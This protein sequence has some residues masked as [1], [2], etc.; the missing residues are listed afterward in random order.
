MKLGE[1]LV[2]RGL[3]TTEQLSHALQTQGVFGGRL[4]TNLVEMGYVTDEDIATALAQQY[5]TP[6]APP[7]WVASIPREVIALVPRAVAEKYRVIPLRQH[8]RCLELGVV[9]PGN[10]ARLDELCFAL[11]TRIRPYVLTE[12]SLNYALER[13]Y[14]TPRSARF[15]RQ[16]R[17]ESSGLME[18][19]TLAEEVERQRPTAS[20]ERVGPARLSPPGGTADFAAYVPHLAAVLTEHDLLDVVFGFL[21]SLFDEVAVLLPRKGTLYPVAAG[22]RHLR[23]PCPAESRVA[24]PPGSL[25]AQL[26][27]KAQIAHRETATDVALREA[28]AALNIPPVR[29]T[30]VPILGQRGTA[31]L[32]LG[33]GL[34]EASLQPHLRLLREFLAKASSALQIVLLRK[35]ILS[36]AA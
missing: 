20:Q 14:G 15:R 10:L 30:V 2:S 12:I 26:A 34:P 23:R 5:A 11:D 16:P 1:I 31:L 18:L 33:Q 3:L 35:Q 32:A 8:M 27:D 17:G 29:L 22:N 19:T 13:Y 25:F 24:M 6:R 4:G 7:E 21:V 36:P 28:C 9:D